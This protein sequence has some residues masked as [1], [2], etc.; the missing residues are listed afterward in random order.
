[1][2]VYDLAYLD[3]AESTVMYL[4]GSRSGLGQGNSIVATRQYLM[5]ELE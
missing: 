2:E 3:G 1:M 5:A 4:G